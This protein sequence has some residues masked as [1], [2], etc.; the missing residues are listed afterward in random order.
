VR[1]IVLINIFSTNSESKVRKK[2][3]KKRPK[4][5]SKDLSEVGEKKLS[6]INPMAFGLLAVK[7]QEN[8]NNDFLRSSLKV[9]SETP[10]FL[11]DKWIASINKLVD[12]IAKA[13]MLDPPDYAE[14]DRVAFE[15]LVVAKI[16][17]PKEDVEYPMPAIICMDDKGWRFYFK[18]SKAYDYTAGKVISFTATVSAHKEGITFLRRPSKIRESSLEKVIINDK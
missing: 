17:P 16:V 6:Q 11:T 9:I 14:S 3:S 1:G 15:N 7:V 4:S 2:R 5:R 10:H 12:S 13:I 18:T 8:P